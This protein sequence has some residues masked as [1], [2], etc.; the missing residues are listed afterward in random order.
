MN[1]SK[2]ITNNI[3]N[4]LRLLNNEETN[5]LNTTANNDVQKE[6]LR[7]L[8]IYIGV[9]VIIIVL[10]LGGYAL[11]RKCVEKRAL[12]EIEREYQL[13]IMNLINSVSS[14]RS[15]HEDKRPH[16]CNN[17][18]PNYIQ[19]Y[20]NEIGNQNVNN[21]IDFNYEERMENIRKKFGNEIV[22]KCLLKKQIEEIQYTKN[23]AEELGDICTICMENFIEHIIISKTPC[24]HIFHKKCFDIYLKGIQKK[25]KL[26]CPNCN[27]NLLIN[28]KYL[29]LR[30]KTKMNEK[31]QKKSSKKDIKDIKE[32]E[33]N[34]ENDF[35]NRNSV[36]TNKNEE[37]IVSSN[38]N[39]IILI[40]KKS[41]KLKNKIGEDRN[42]NI[43]NC[44]KK[45]EDNI[46]NPQ[47]IRIRR[48]ESY[49]K[50]DKDTIIPFSEQNENIDKSEN[51][52]NKKRI[53]FISNFDKNN[54][55]SLKSALTNNESKAKL[56][57]NKRKINLNVVNSEREG[58]M[59]N[60]KT[61]GAINSSSKQEN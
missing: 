16:S 48:N 41:P 29:K 14:D 45:D 31:K 37:N 19:N 24:E 10:I 25:D 61:C 22:I 58:I 55:N 13:M 40:K 44:K 35:K 7:D 3:I 33:L 46:Y 4:I 8:Y 28:K 1:Y 53:V 50:L 30:A 26:L 49:S 42:I 60:K 6:Q 21:S 9:L 56:Y 47:Q 2:I 15:S 36:M 43:K 12:E 39:E 34:L 38:N 20:I 51:E 54:S 59:I 52:K 57:S 32:S 23:F 11:Y 27:Q 5:K 18:N 17:I